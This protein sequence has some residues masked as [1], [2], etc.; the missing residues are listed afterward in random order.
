MKNAMEFLPQSVRVLNAGDTKSVSVRFAAHNGTWE[1][2]PEPKKVA[3]EPG[4]KEESG[5]L[6]KEV[7]GAGGRLKAFKRLWHSAG[8]TKGGHGLLD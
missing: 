1:D 6:A 5:S 2:W 7:S 3:K 4:Q 8:G